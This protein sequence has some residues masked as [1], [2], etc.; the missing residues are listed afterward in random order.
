MMRYVLTHKRKIVLILIILILTVFAFYYI[1]NNSINHDALMIKQEYEFYNNQETRDEVPY[2]IV[3]LKRN[4]D[5]TNI[6]LSTALEKIDKSS[7]IIFIG[8]AKDFNSRYALPV[9][10]QVA[11]ENGKEVLYLDGSHLRDEYVVKNKELKKE[12]GAS[13]N[14]YKLLE[15]LGDSLNDYIVYD[16]KGE[17]YP[18]GEKRLEYPT[19]V[20]FSNGEIKG[21]HVGVD[22]QDMLNGNEKLIK[23]YSTYIKKIE[24]NV[25]AIESTGC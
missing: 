16:D 23:I 2:P 12:K 11:E 18:V 4:M 1:Y 6:T 9:I 3:Y 14:Y 8:D 13:K 15:L 10:L 25:C 7:G 5:I 17:S 24:S 19:V 20:F 21:V 22:D